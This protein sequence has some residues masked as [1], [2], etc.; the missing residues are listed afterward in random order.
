M[1]NEVTRGIIAGVLK[2]ADTVGG[3]VTGNTV[4]VTQSFDDKVFYFKK[5]KT[6]L[7]VERKDD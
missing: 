4:P 3:G 1:R 7:A 2:E 5:K 6:E